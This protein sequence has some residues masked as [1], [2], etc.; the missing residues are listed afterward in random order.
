[1][2]KKNID[3]FLEFMNYIPSAPQSPKQMLQQASSNDEITIDTWREQWLRQITANKEKYG[4]FAEHSVGSLNGRH[5]GMTAIIAG[6]G[7]SLKENAHLLK[8][9]GN[10]LLISCLHNYHFFKDLGIKVDY[11][12]TLDAGDITIEEVSEGGKLT[13]EEYFESTKSEN[14]IA[15]IGSH[16][17]LLEKWQG[18]VLFYNAPMPD[19]NLIKQIDAI[20][21]FN[22]LL[23]TGGN[24]LGACFY[25]AKLIGCGPIAF[26][27]A[28]FSFS[29][30]RKF[31]A[32]DSKYDAKVGN[33]IR[34]IDV[35][36]N[37]AVTWQSYFN[38]KLWFEAMCER[39]PGIYIN[40]TEGGI[41]GSYFE[42]NIQAI[43]Q[44]ALK[45]FL[46]IYNMHKLIEKSCLNPS[47]PERQLLF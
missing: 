47:D 43:R 15:F 5:Q 8:N 44:M 42:G 3:L 1:M 12:L 31:H 37:K 16:P 38:F 25:F 32:W 4:S 2:L 13:S 39:V 21:T 27:G 28:D 41:L 7:P 45:D 19:L 29:Q 9:R 34:H 18:N 36:G 23:S 10:I 33:V 20:E 6:S 26:I 46:E 35:F 11:W 40:C 22:A 24:V 30:N 17:K 14:L